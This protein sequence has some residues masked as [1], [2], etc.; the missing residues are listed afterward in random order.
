[1]PA[2]KPIEL[3]SQND[4]HTTRKAARAAAEDAMN[5]G[6]TLPVNPPAELKEYPIA[7]QVWR[8]TVRLFD[9]L[10]ANILTA[11]DRDLLIEYSLSMQFIDDLRR[12]RAGAIKAKNFE[13]L[14]SLDQRLDRKAARIDNLRQQLYLTPRS[15]A[16]VVP[17]DKPT[18]EPPE[19]LPEGGF[20]LE[21]LINNK[22]K[23]NGQ[24]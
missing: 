11:L 1:M 4:R 3:H 5:P 10:Q 19:A 7:M 6:R 20:W 9:G 16:G 15:R 17:A 2:T 24:G 14:L 8:R 13:L 18:D 22:A 23:D 21:D 12:L